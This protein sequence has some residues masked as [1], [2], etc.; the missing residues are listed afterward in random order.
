[1]MLY[2]ILYDKKAHS[3]DITPNSNDCISIYV[4]QMRKQE[5][6]EAISIK[7]R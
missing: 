6:I 7:I 4:G 2:Y 3:L 5:I 1:M